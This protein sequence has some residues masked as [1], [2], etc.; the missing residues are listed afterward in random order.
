MSWLLSRKVRPKEKGRHDKATKFF[1]LQ[2]FVGSQSR[3][4]RKREAFESKLWKLKVQLYLEYI[5]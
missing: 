2:L 3:K 1:F 5:Y 4:G